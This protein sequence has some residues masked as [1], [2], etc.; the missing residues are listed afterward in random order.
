[1]HLIRNVLSSFKCCNTMSIRC[2]IVIMIYTN[3]SVHKNDLGN[4][5]KTHINVDELEG[6]EP[7]ATKVQSDLINTHTCPY[8]HAEKHEAKMTFCVH[9]KT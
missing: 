8:V 3:K 1:M 6:H 7:S 2:N 5:Y 9:T 4:T